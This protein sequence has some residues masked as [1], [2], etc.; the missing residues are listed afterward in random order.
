M[1]SLGT[2]WVGVRAKLDRLRSDFVEAKKFVSKGTKT[3]Q[4]AMSALTFGHPALAASAVFVTAAL[5][6]R[7]LSMSSIAVAA[8]FER[9]GIKLNKLTDGRGMET[10]LEINKWALEMPV[11]TQEATRS[12]VTM[13][14]MGL[15]PTIKKMQS[16]T[17]IAAIFGEEAL[18]RVSLALG[19]MS[20][21]GRLSAQDL[22]QLA[23]V[24]IS[25]RKILREAF[26][27]SVK[28]IQ[29]S[30]IEM[31]K[32]LDEFWKHFKKNFGGAAKE[33]MSS[34][35]GLVVTF[36]GYIV[37]IQRQVMDAGIFDALKKKLAEVNQSMRDWLRTN[38]DW[39]KN[40]LPQ[41]VDD[42]IWLTS[43][44]TDLIKAMV[45]FSAWTYK[46]QWKMFFGAKDLIS[47]RTARTRD[48]SKDM[49]MWEKL[50]KAENEYR[51]AIGAEVPKNPYLD[52]GD[53]PGESADP[54]IEAYNKLAEKT[55]EQIRL[56]AELAKKE[57]KRLAMLEKLEEMYARNRLAARMAYSAED[58][59]GW[60]TDFFIGMPD[61]EKRA[62]EIFAHRDKLRKEE[63]EKALADA[64]E[65]AEQRKILFE[66]AEANR[67]EYEFEQWREQY[68]SLE[69][70]TEQTAGHMESTFSDLF[71]DA[72]RG[73]LKSLE[74]YFA[75]FLKSLQRMISDFMA[76][77]LVQRMFQN[78][79]GFGGGGINWGNGGMSVP[80]GQNDFGFSS[81][82]YLGERVVGRGVRSGASY[83][84]GESGP[85]V[86]LPIGRGGSGG[87][88][89]KPNVIINIR[90]QSGQSLTASNA[91]ESFNGRDYVIDIVMDAHER[92]VNGFRDAM[93]R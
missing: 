16:L 83:E 20:S 93:R 59:K 36:K 73:E 88:G 90:N 46:I 77:K 56:E 9:M 4:S 69:M 86:V 74:D 42:I 21:M 72:M 79:G 82:G 31:N 27:M 23:Q 8:D 57:E 15:E 47:G 78:F 71:F 39:I 64:K 2:A 63:K 3:L 50:Y 92:N 62:N 55:L 33:A 30:G 38:Q 24:G 17:D 54:R 53:E 7:K 76:Q 26:G 43:K 65:L 10:L 60:N 67:L 75:S 28:E 81:G 35:Q 52:Y 80:S 25:S 14:A 19:Q 70:L 45:G 66:E 48:L 6:M 5:A 32:I 91:G 18:G 13:Q 40:D 44:F 85:E 68:E 1:P 22:N 49:A 84:F 51:K 12:F 37:E 34:W 11:N 89:Q 61:A 87:G 41:L 29:A 58:A